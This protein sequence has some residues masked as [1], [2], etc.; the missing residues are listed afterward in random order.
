MTH[1]R[2]VGSTLL[3]NPTISA[4]WAV[5]ALLLGVGLLMLGNGLQS[6][7]LGVRASEEGFGNSITGFVMSGYFAGFFAGSLMTPKGVRRVGHVRVFA[8]LASLASI[9]ILLHAVFVNPAIWVLMRF[10]TGLSYAGL[11]IVAESW[12]NDRSDNATRGRLLSLYLV[13]SYLGMAGGQ[14]LLNAGNPGSTR[15]FILV[16]VVIS[17]AV[18][19]ILLSATKGPD[20]GAPRPVKLRELY[21]VSPLGTVATFATGMANGTVFGMGAVYARN[22]GLSV[23]EVSIFMT[24]VVLGG[25]ILQWPIGKVSDRVDRRFVITSVTFA[26]AGAAVLAQVVAGVSDLGLLALAGLFGGLT[27]SMYSLCIAYVNDFLEPDQMVA[28]SSGLTM[29]LGAGAVLGPLTSGWAM[30]LVGVGGFFWYLALVHAAIGVFAVWR[31]TQRASAPTDEQGPY[32]AVPSYGA[33]G[34][35]TTAAEVYAEETQDEEDEGSS[36]PDSGS[37]GSEHAEGTGAWPSDR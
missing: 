22:S 15:L 4:A 7:L 34:V 25:A 3:Q 13:I 2:D 32:V 24:I 9:A 30:D 6:S 16:S 10:V 33:P 29:A 27:L 17:F 8:A 23:A 18:V 37:Q 36:E 21:R 35:S 28:A 5:W 20:Y 19:P 1:P 26:A 11:Y 12:L 31:M 14:L